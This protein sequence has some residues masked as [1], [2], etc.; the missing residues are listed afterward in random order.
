VVY[1]AVFSADL[2]SAGVLW[3]LEFEMP[4]CKIYHRITLPLSCRIRLCVKSTWSHNSV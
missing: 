2:G 4:P 1:D 3:V